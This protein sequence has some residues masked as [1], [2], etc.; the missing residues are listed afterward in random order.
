MLSGATSARVRLSSVPK[1]NIAQATHEGG[2][3]GSF[4]EVGIGWLTIGGVCRCAM[5]TVFAVPKGS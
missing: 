5:G 1:R 4:A 2:T 3:E